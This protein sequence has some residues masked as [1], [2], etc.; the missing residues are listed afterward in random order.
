MSC[1]DHNIPPMNCLDHSIPF[2]SRYTVG[3]VLVL[4]QSYSLQNCLDLGIRNFLDQNPH[5]FLDLSHRDREEADFLCQVEHAGYRLH[6]GH[7]VTIHAHVFQVDPCL[8]LEV[9]E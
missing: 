7:R 8:G 6:I 9:T 2:R 3:T 4:D 5:L 1:L